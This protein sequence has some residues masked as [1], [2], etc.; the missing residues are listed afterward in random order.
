VERF[1]V[2]VP[3]S[4]FILVFSAAFAGVMF[5]G[6]SSMT[7]I[8]VRYSSSKRARDTS[9]DYRDEYTQSVQELLNREPR[10]EH[11]VV[12]G[13][14]LSGRGTEG[15]VVIDEMGEPDETTLIG[16]LPDM[17]SLLRD[18]DLVAPYIIAEIE[19]YQIDK[20]ERRYGWIF[21]G[22]AFAFLIPGALWGFLTYGLLEGTFVM[23]QVLIA[24]VLICAVGFG[25]SYYWKKSKT[26]EAD[27]AV[28]TKY[29]RFRE[30]LHVLVTNHYTQPFGITSFR[31]RL[32]RINEKMGTPRFTP[33]PDAG[34]D[35]Q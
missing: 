23:L 28:A 13:V 12:R 32:D 5:W 8:N 25:I 31:T 34:I 4:L 9:S 22:L 11:L 29:P 30:A 18:P 2:L 10:Y 26:V 20:K 33:S 14:K 19:R 15:L 1:L 21:V 3:W 16:I 17:L 27:V 24:Y 7:K 6:A 35:L